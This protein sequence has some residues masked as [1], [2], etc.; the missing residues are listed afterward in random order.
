MLL[1]N[2]LDLQYKELFKCLVTYCK[3]KGEIKTLDKSNFKELL[4]TELPI[5]HSLI[6]RFTVCVV[7]SKQ[8]MGSK[9]S[10]A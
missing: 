4:L 9:L 10:F 7:A 8:P 3:R 1:N 2:P 5:A 6:L